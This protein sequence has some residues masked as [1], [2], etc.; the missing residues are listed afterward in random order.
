MKIG[1]TQKVSFAFWPKNNMTLKSE[2]QPKTILTI[3]LAQSSIYRLADKN[4]TDDVVNI[5]SE[6]HDP[7]ARKS[8]LRNKKEKT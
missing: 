5:T 4:H 1:E 8:H 7:N 3:R 6:L 2:T